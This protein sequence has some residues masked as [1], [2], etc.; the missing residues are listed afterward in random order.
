[1]RSVKLGWGKGLEKR[2]KKHYMNERQGG[3]K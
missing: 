2:K 3:E 1:M